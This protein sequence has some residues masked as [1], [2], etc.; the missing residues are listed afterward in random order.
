MEAVL[1]EAGQN[2]NYTRTL[3]DPGGENEIVMFKSCFPNSQLEGNPGDL[4]APGGDALSVSNA[5]Y[6][7]NEILK[8]FK[9]RPDKLFIVITAPPVSDP[10]LAANARAFNKWLMNSWLMENDYPYK[11]VAVWDFYNILTSQS[12]HHRFT[13]GQIE[14]IANE[15]SNT[16]FYP[17]G[18]DHPSPEGSQKATAEF[19]PMLNVFYHLWQ[20]NL[21]A[22]VTNPQNSNVQPA[23]TSEAEQPNSPQANG[24]ISGMI[25]NFE[26]DPPLDTNGWEA[27]ADEATSST[28]SIGVDQNIKHEGNGSLRIDYDIH[29]DGW[30][31]F[32]LL[33]NTLQ[34][35][36]TAQGITFAY[37]ASKPGMGFHVLA[38]G[39]SA[40]NLSGYGY[41]LESTQESVDGWVVVDVPWSQ[42]P[43]VEWEPDAGSPIDPS[44]IR[45]VGFSLGGTDSLW[46]D[47]IKL[48]GVAAPTN[49]N[50]TMEQ[51]LSNQPTS[52]EAAG[53]P[54]TETAP[55]ESQEQPGGESEGPLGGICSCPGALLLA[56]MAGA[57][58]IRR[59]L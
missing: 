46:V 41:Y 9:T 17:S 57:L 49:A 36:Q 33:Y 50:P 42:L 58:W 21:G 5:K 6:V 48:M 10:T 35:W 7:Y 15:T 20:E 28:V 30:G 55:L 16:L 43:R 12:N 38:L 18:D 59:V 52:Q 39:G 56:L 11:N 13:N 25:D 3:S 44:K 47:D 26:G 32:N 8:Y 51:Q 40:D 19:I 37:H 14:Y 23:S 2:S 53:Q 29:P 31:T 1:N 27:W 54:I 45:G 22:G 4:P 34:N 24:L